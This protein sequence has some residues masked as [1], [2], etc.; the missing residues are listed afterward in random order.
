M[1]FTRQINL[2]ALAVA[3]IALPSNMKE[4]AHPATGGGKQVSQG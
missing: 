2:H 1:M 4:A 3:G